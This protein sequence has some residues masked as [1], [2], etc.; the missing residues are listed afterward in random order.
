MKNKHFH[1]NRETNSQHYSEKSD[2]PQSNSNQSPYQEE[3]QQ[4]HSTESY[5]NRKRHREMPSEE[6]IK[7]ESLIFI[8]KLRECVEEDKQLQRENKPSLEKLKF[9]PKIRTFLANIHYQREFLDQDGLEVL[10]NWL[11][12]NRDGTYPPL[13]QLSTILEVLFNLTSIETDHLQRCNIGGYVM[14]ISNSKSISS[15]IKKKASE[16]IKKWAR[17]IYKISV[18]YS[19]GEFEND[20]SKYQEF[21]ENAFACWEDEF[22]GNMSENNEDD[23]VE[24][25]TKK[26]KKSTQISLDNLQEYETYHNS[27]IPKKGLFDFSKK[28]VAYVEEKKGDDLNKLSY[29]NGLKRKRK[30]NA[31][32]R[33]YN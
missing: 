4:P 30:T 24:G 20:D 22:N 21:K 17:I 33:H 11:K 32:K 29:L 12:R 2:S 3:A 28:P 9:L 19:K 14:E 25:G 6:E 15:N 5:L 16:L 13:N 23:I 1:S 26:N 31:R 27:I 7:N 8:S 10:Q 18:D